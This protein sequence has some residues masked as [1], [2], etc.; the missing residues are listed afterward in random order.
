MSLQ[1]EQQISE[2]DDDDV[3]LTRQEIVFSQMRA[4]GSKW[5]KA[6][7]VVE[8]IIGFI[9]SILGA[10]EIFIIPMSESKDGS[11]Q[12]VMDKTNSYGAGFFAGLVMVITGSTALRAT[13]S[14]RD[15]TVVRFFNLTILSL[16]LYAVLTVLLIASYSEGWTSP[17][18]YKPGS[19]MKEVHIFV[20]IF[21]VLGLMFA[22]TS[23]VQYVE[24]ICC[25]EVPL[26]S[27]WVSCFCPC[28]FSKKRRRLSFD[29][30]LRE[31][32]H[33]FSDLI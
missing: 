4:R 15:T 18:K 25:G 7:G 29:S 28:V 23:F 12:V 17:D 33:S 26:W 2:D 1:Q 16:L 11:N 19:R 5:P 3:Q 31:E 9:L 8:I 32:F 22:V 30:S 13:M 27:M 21:T 24:V 20:T 14:Q 10:L 6:I